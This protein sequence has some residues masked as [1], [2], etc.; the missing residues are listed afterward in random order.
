MINL[1]LILVHRM[2]IFSEKQLDVYII[3]STVNHDRF[4]Y[5]FDNSCFLNKDVR[6]GATRREGNDK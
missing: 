6:H 5:L 1:F 3:V 2:F 4:S